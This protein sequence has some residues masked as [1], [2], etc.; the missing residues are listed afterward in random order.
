MPHDDILDVKVFVEKE[1]LIETFDGFSENQIHDAVGKES[2]CF[3]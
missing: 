3:I 2:V 1:H